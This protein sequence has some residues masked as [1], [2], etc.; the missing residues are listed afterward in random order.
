MIVD[1]CPVSLPPVNNN[2]CGQ[3]KMGDTNIFGQN[4]HFDIASDAMNQEQYNTF[5]QGV[6]DGSYVTFLSYI[7]MSTNMLSSNRNWLNVQFTETSCNG[8]VSPDPPMKDW[9]CMDGSCPNN[10]AAPVCQGVSSTH[11]LEDGTTL[12]PG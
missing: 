5:Y 1:E 8:A 9:G 12:V 4:W 3:C 7:Q 2:N 11:T 10:D 6:T